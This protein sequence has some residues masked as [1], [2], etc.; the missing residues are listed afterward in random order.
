MSRRRN[1]QTKTHTQRD[2]FKRRM[3]ERYG[4]TVNRHEYRFMV[5]MIQNGEAEF[6]EKQSNRVSAFWLNLTVD[7]GV[8]NSEIVRV[9]VIYD[10][11]RKTLVTALPPEGEIDWLDADEHQQAKFDDLYD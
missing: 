7:D 4:L 5:E 8:G 6:I 11:L 10:K 3:M 1:K 2:H 9:R